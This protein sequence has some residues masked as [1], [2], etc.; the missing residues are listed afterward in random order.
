[1]TSV[2]YT[3]VCVCIYIYL[4]IL[5]ENKLLAYHKE[6]TVPWYALKFDNWGYIW[7][8]SHYA[9]IWLSKYELYMY[10]RIHNKSINLKQEAWLYKYVPFTYENYVYV[11]KNQLIKFMWYAL[12]HIMCLY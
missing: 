11:K 8:V 5:R 4:A 1:M 2:I 3:G 6:F 10:T 7:Q 9:T 12:V